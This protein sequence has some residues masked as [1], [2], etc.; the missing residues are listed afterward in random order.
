MVYCVCD[1]KTKY[2]IE[3]KLMPPLTTRPNASPPL[4]VSTATSLGCVLSW[5]FCACAYLPGENG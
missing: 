4:G 3:M 2:N 1:T 5:V